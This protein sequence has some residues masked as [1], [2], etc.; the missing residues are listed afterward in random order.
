MLIQQ[1]KKQGIITFKVKVC[2]SSRKQ[3]AP[4]ATA[5]FSQTVLFFRTLWLKNKILY[6]DYLISKNLEN[7]VKYVQLFDVSSCNI[8][9]RDD[10][11]KVWKRR[12]IYMM[13]SRVSSVS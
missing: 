11:H 3:K 7:N 12:Q 5:R 1:K 6:V 2:P 4:I 8:K 9:Y 13:L 10:V